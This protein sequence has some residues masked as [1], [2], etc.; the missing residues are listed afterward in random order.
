V[1]KR[2][3]ELA[4]QTGGSIKVFDSPEEAVAGAQ[5][6][7]T[8][9][10]SSMGREHESEKR[11]KIFAPYEVNRRLFDLAA[12]D[13]VFLHCLPAH[14]GLEVTEDVIDSPQSIIYDQAENRLHVGKAIL[15]TLIV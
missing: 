12:P 15:A 2:A 7:Y 14:R 5:A 3:L 11:A 10:W 4:A 8:D 1:V 6:V 13:A 9:V